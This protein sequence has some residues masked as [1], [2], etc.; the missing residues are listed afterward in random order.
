MAA[1]VSYDLRNLCCTSSDSVILNSGDREEILRSVAIKT[2]QSLIESIF[3]LPVEKSEYGPLVTLPDKE[4]MKLPRKQHVPEPKPETKW[5]KFA[6]EKGIKNTKKERMVYDEV[7]DVYRPRYGY[8]SIKSVIDETPVIEI[9]NGMDPYADP[10]S[11]ARK[12]KAE[13]RSKNLKR[14]LKTRKPI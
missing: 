3:S 6:R 4:I 12:E 13:N 5:E 1:E 8:K 2:G 14:Q 10:W 7:N 11:E 9:K